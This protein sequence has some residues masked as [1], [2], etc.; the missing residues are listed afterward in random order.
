MDTLERLVANAETL[1]KEGYYDVRGETE[2]SPSFLDA[3]GSPTR[4][5][6]V[7][8]EPNFGSPF[9]RTQKTVA[10]IDAILKATVTAKPLWLSVVAE[11]MI[12]G[13]PSRLAAQ[14][15]S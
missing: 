4:I 5:S 6:D 2:R 12:L 13:P 8:A 1:L 10:R 11:P 7:V 9:I 15:A 3:L 14:A